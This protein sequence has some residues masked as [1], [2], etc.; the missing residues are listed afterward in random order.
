[1]KYRKN[2]LILS[3]CSVFLGSGIVILVKTAHS[4]NLG[5]VPFTVEQTEVFYRY[6]AGDF[7]A[8][9]DSTHG[10]RT[11]GSE[12]TRKTVRAPDGTSVKQAIIYDLLARKRVVLDGLTLSSTTT[13]LADFY[14]QSAQQKPSQCAEAVS[15]TSTMLGFAVVKAHNE[16]L[17]P[18]KEVRTS[19][20]WLA[21][22]LDCY[23]LE[24]TLTLQP[25]GGTP[26]ITNVRRVVSV[27]LGE[28]E[29]QEFTTVMTGYVERAPSEVFAEHA[30]KYPGSGNPVAPDH[31][32][33]LDQI[34]SSKQPFGLPKPK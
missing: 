32:R 6:P 27:K 19:D 2:L 29:A 26:H 34:Y 4:Q 12:F 9:Q 33:M 3:V 22:A 20:A 30:R 7:G 14:V 1:M 17:L 25:A 23:P 18:N 16:N 28:P 24:N 15:V 31:A 8:Q 5:R 10:V 13:P 21:P 11:D